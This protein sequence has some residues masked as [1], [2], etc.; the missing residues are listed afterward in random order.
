[1]S[2]LADLL[3]KIKQPGPTK[4]IP[5]NLK[6]IVSSSAQRSA[7]KKRIILLSTFFLGAV[8]LGF[9]VVYFIQSFNQKT[10]E[11]GQRLEVRE[12]GTEGRGEGSGVG[13]QETEDR[14]QGTER[15]GQKTEVKRQGSTVG[16]RQPITD[17]QQ[18]TA[19]NQQ[20]IAD[21]RADVGAHL[22]S[23]K[24]YEM[25]KDYSKALLEYKKIIEVDKNNF[26]AMN[27]IAYLLLH[28]GQAEES[29][30]YS[31]M[32][33]DINKD[34]VPALINLAVAYA[35]LGNTSTA[36]A[37]LKQALLIEASNASVLLNLALLY[38]KKGDYPMA[39]EYFSRLAA[40]GDITGSMGLARIYEKQNKIGDALKVYK[41]I[42][43]LNSIDNRTRQMVSERISLLSGK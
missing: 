41:N 6:N 17:N 23:A 11:R 39:S 10:E 16:N 24:E 21:T 1:M 12:H 14:K 5:P 35:K 9:L 31:E 33:L 3:S 8:V 28:L 25:Q 37:Y 27:N 38:E 4:D 32:S 42:Y 2:L 19:D 29:I 22:Y 40:L 30:K 20:P 13:E 15:R 18:L 36:E 26:G 43:A 7:F 34:Y